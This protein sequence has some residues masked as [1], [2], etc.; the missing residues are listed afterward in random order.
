LLAQAV[1]SCLDQR[2][3]GP[4]DYEIIVVDN[5]PNKSAQCVV[6]DINSTQASVWYV[7]EP[8]RG[9]A[10]ARNTGVSVARGDYVVFLDDDECATPNWLSELLKHASL[11][12]MAVFG[13]IHEAIDE[14]LKGKRS[15]FDF[16]IV[17]RSFDRADGEDISDCIYQL[18]TGNSLFSRR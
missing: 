10:R 9:V 16:S 8:R 13:P 11:G 12:A 5:C 18:G 4:S 6:G 1:R 2:D 15:V 14:G 7:S 17:S 3:V